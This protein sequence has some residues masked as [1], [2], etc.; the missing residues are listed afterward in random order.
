MLNLSLQVGIYQASVN[1]PLKSLYT[2]IINSCLGQSNNGLGGIQNGAITHK[3][4]E[5]QQHME[6]PRIPHHGAPQLNALYSV[7]LSTQWTLIQSLTG[8]FT[9]ADYCPQILG[10]EKTQHMLA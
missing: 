1:K 3:H 8:F 5:R 6:H 10:P 4:M 9:Q 2:Q 7:D